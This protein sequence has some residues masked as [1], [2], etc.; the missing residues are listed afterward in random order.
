M[1]GVREKWTDERLDDLNKRVDDGFREM[2]E[3]FARIDARLDKMQHLMVQFAI[4]IIAA[5]VTLYATTIGL[6]LTQL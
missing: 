2:R 6:V 5:M 1:Q 3:G 4:A